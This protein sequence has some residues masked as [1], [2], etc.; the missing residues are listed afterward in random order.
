MEYMD[1]EAQGY[2]KKDPQA[3]ILALQADIIM[4]SKWRCDR[5][6]RTMEYEGERWER[7]QS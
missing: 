1:P 7:K 3:L 5:E 4:I 2:W 6:V